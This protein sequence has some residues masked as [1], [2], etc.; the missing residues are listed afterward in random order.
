A[1]WAEAVIGVEPSA[2]MRGQAEARSA[3]MP[4]GANVRYQAGYANAT[5]LPD[6]CADIVTCSQSL[7][8]M[9]PESTF[10]EV[11]RIL[12]PGG[13]FA[14]YDC[15]WPPTFHWQVEQAYSTCQAQA[16]AAEQAH[17]LSR[18]V[19]SWEKSGHLERIRAS[20]RF[21]FAKEILLHHVE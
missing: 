8:W 12:R 7:H 4:D 11:A 3:A 2:D 20:G 15:D 17:G 13:V 21:R 1:G 19:R 9:E 14:A 6:G 5:G 18:E 10:A 16:H